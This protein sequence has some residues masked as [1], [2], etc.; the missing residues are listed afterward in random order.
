MSTALSDLSDAFSECEMRG[1]TPHRIRV[2]RKLF[3]TMRAANWMSA[4]TIPGEDG[5]I[6]LWFYRDVAVQPDDSMEPDAFKMTV[7]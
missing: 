4:R 1:K 6:E 7:L 5:A 2:G 3:E